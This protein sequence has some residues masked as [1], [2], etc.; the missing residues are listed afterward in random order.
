[1]KEDDACLCWSAMNRMRSGLRSAD[2]KLRTGPQNKTLLPLLPQRFLVR[3]VFLLIPIPPQNK[4]SGPERGISIISHA[5]EQQEHSWLPPSKA[6]RGH[7]CAVCSCLEFDCTW[8]WLGRRANIPEPRPA[9]VRSH[10]VSGLERL[11]IFT[12]NEWRSTPGHLNY[13]LHPHLLPTA[14]QSNEKNT[15]EGSSI[16]RQ[17]EG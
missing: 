2:W 17:H 12:F 16:V 14:A 3:A 9:G 13:S 1:M 7:V 6:S 4:S 5:H 8:S 15:F 11:S 10:V